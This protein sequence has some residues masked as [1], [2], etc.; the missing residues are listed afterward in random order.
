V[1]IAGA[2]SVKPGAVQN[3]LLGNA[4]DR[5]REVGLCES[6]PETPGSRANRK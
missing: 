4:P 1:T 2:L 5:H 3:G 6:I